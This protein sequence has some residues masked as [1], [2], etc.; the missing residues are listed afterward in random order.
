MKTKEKP[1]SQPAAPV[2]H[3]RQAFEITLAPGSEYA[4][5]SVDIIVGT[6]LASALDAEGINQQQVQSAIRLEKPKRTVD[7]LVPEPERRLFQV[8]I[9]SDLLARA[10]ARRE[11]DGLTWQQLVEACFRRYLLEQPEP[12]EQREPAG[13]VQS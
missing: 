1:A 10:E 12:V 11:I 9:D 3:A 6:D 5:G 13:E 4:N 2:V 8:R 7:F